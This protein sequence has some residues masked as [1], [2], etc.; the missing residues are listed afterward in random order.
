MIVVVLAVVLIALAVAYVVSAVHRPSQRTLPGFVERV[1][2]Y[3]PA[4]VVQMHGSD[5]D[6]IGWTR[7]D[8]A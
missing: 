4:P 7:K 8:A 5:G 1:T 2:D 3:T 6:V